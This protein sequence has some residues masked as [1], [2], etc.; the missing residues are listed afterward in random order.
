MLL[1]WLSLSRINKM[2]VITTF[3]VITLLGIGFVSNK[4]F[5]DNNAVEE[6]AEEMLKKD[7][8]ITVEFSGEKPKN[9][10]N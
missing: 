9:G 10:N 5:G 6:I 8:N 3:F 7:Y 2:I 4:F 1:G